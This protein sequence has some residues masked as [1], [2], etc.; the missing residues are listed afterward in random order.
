MWGLP[1]V[2]DG[3]GPEGTT[4]DKPV[5]ADHKPNLEGSSH[6]IAK[7]FQAHRTYDLFEYLLK[8]LLTKQPSNPLEHMLECLE[9]EHPRD[10]GPLKVILTSPP[11]AFDRGTVAKR[12]AN[13]FGL[14][15]IGSGELLRQNR[16]DTDSVDI[17]DDEKTAQLVIQK[18]QK[19]EELMTGWVLDGFPRT[20]FQTTF[21]Q[22]HSF[23][24]T[25]VLVLNAS[26]EQAFARQHRIRQGEIEGRAVAPE[27]LER[28]LRAHV[29][30]EA[31]L[32]MYQDRLRTIDTQ[33]GEEYV[34]AEMVRLVRRLPRSAAPRLAPRVVLLGAPGVDVSEHANRLAVQ[35]GAVFVDGA[36]LSKDPDSSGSDPLG[37]VGV[38]LRHRDCSQQG[39]VMCGFPHTE[40]LAHTLS[41]DSR[42][43]PTRVLALQASGAESEFTINIHGIFQKLQGVGRLC[44]FV[45]AV[46]AHQDVFDEL[47]ELVD[48]PVPLPMPSA[49]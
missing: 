3:L 26:K 13:E 32:D 36:A 21:L 6:E 2:P 39:Y 20:K 46:S 42:L 48:R 17:V 11:G 41:Q 44:T 9:A 49:K 37:K 35:L 18:L 40:D 25:H 33:P 23:V 10:W 24:P 7:Y 45:P 38:R 47:A 30:V 29:S 22:E 15:Y 31:A 4:L 8:E 12:L 14:T 27:I 1:T 5:R 28:K 19:A 43:A 34:W 16:V